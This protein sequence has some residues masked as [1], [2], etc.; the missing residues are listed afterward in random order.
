MCKVLSF[1]PFLYI[2]TACASVQPNQEYALAHL[3]L[4]TAKK[5]EA[6]KF[7][8]KSYSKA[9]SFYRKAVAFYKKQNYEEAENFFAKSINLAEKAELKARIRKLQESE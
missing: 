6:D 2:L 9:L 8:P 3:A 1:L 5:F 4:S 7:S